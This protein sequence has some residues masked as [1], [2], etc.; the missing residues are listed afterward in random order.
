[1]IVPFILGSKIDLDHARKIQA[2]LD[3]YGIPHETYVASAHKVP[4]VTLEIINDYNEK[5]ESVVFVTIAGRSNALSGLVSA[6][7]HFPVVA[8]P[9]F[10]DKADYLTNIHSTLQMPSET[11][12]LTVVDPKNA[13]QAVA[14]LLSLT[15]KDL[16]KKV[17]NHI[18]IVKHSFS[19][20]PVD[21]D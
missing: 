9:P 1:M 3:D 4:T 18:K 6:N 8:C 16:A 21:N 19:T 10:S 15:N 5:K 13:G 11:P 7:T 14:R 20:N 17:N 12:C 2:V